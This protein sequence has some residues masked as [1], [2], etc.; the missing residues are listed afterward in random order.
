LIASAF[1]DI[2][3][4]KT[5]LSIQPLFQKTTGMEQPKSYYRIRFND[6]DSFKHL[7]NTHYIDYMINAREDH[8]KEF[9]QL[10]MTELYQKGLSWMVSTHEIVYLRPAVYGETVCIKSVLIKASDDSLLVEMVMMDEAASRIKAILWTKFIHINA[11]AGKR[12]KHPEW[13]MEIAK[14]LE[15]PS[16]KDVDSLKERLN[17]VSSR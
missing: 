3:Q 1:F 4:K 16:L 13:F 17:M 7:H 6:C 8:L 9:H 14:G 15:D 5:C 11:A 12:E 2:Y 10:E